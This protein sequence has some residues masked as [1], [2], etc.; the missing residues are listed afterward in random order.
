MDIFPNQFTD[1]FDRINATQLSDRNDKLKM[2]QCPQE[3]LDKTLCFSQ[4]PE[5]T[6][7]IEQ[8]INSL[9]YKDNSKLSFKIEPCNYRPCSKRTI[10]F[11][12]CECFKKYY[13]SLNCKIL[14]KIF[15]ED[16]CQISLSNFF[17]SQSNRIIKP[18]M[19]E[20]Y[21]GLKGIRNIGNTCYMSTD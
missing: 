19:K 8:G 9:F 6:I 10:L 17:I 1:N 21:I 20:S 11:T 13:C 2:K 4:F 7:I 12:Y 16:E 5:L 18:F 14:D 15:H 3:I